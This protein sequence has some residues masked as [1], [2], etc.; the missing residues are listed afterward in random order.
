MNSDST[1]E[2]MQLAEMSS[3]D[4]DLLLSGLEAC[5][6]RRILEIGVSAGATTLFLLDALPKSA[7]LYSVDIERHWYVDNTKETGFVASVAHD[8]QRHPQWD[9]MTGTDVSACLDMIGKDIDFVVLDTTHEMPGE[10]LSFLAV[11]PYMAQNAV[12][13]LHDI[14]IHVIAKSGLLPND[15]HLKS[16][17]TS[18]LFSAISSVDK[19][20]SNDALPNA[21][22]VFIDKQKAMDEIYMVMNL[23]FMDWNYLPPAAVIAKTLRMVK[24]HYPPRAVDMFEHALA[25]NMAKLGVD[26]PA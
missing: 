8:A 24:M 10:F 19:R 15:M 20:V 13:F 3:N 17:C 5:A 2:W 1:N 21:G 9:L 26:I 12:L 22:L 14:G 7:R 16:H 4:W 6:P 23:L 25:Y 18:L 11:L